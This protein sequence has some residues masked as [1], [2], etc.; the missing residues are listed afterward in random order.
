MEWFL[1][2]IAS[3]IHSSYKPSPSIYCS[4][5]PGVILGPAASETLGM[6]SHSTF[7]HAFRVIPGQLKWDV[8][9]AALGQVLGLQK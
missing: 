4:G 1:Q 3:F 8:V 7:L 2:V 9:C 5:F 6:E